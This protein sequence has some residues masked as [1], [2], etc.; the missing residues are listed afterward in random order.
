MDISFSFNCIVKVKHGGGSLREYM[1]NCDAALAQ[2]AAETFLSIFR[3]FLRVDRVTLPL[4]KTLDQL[5]SSGCFSKL[6]ESDRLLYRLLYI[7]LCWPDLAYPRITPE[8]IA[9]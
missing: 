2:R 8:K 1:Y 5:M 6:S 3:D 9:A 7:M 4:L